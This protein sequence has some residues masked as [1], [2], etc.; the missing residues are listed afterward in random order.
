MR[1]LPAQVNKASQWQRL[2]VGMQTPLT[3]ECLLGGENSPLKIKLDGLSLF[4]S[5]NQMLR[6]LRLKRKSEDI[7]MIIFHL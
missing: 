2:T 7:E 3:A 6:S 5:L 4:F 1:L